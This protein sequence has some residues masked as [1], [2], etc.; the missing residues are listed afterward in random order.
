MPGREG[1]PFGPVGRRI[2][3]LIAVAVV[4]FAALAF[5]LAKNSS[6][7]DATPTQQSDT[8]A[9]ALAFAPKS[10]PA[11]IGVDTGSPQASLVLGALVNRIAG[12][13]LTANDISP[14]PG[15]EAVVAPRDPRTGRSQFSMG[16][17]DGGALK[18]L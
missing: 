7:D 6:K 11:L 8:R 14:I 18:Q 5:V 17:S 13:A 1:L 16:D 3:A 15:M 4:V 10:S 2:A 9:E 12:G